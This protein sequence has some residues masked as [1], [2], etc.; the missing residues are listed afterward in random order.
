MRWWRQ[1]QLDESATAVDVRLTLDDVM[2]LGGC[3][4]WEGLQ[5]DWAMDWTLMERDRRR[6]EARVGGGRSTGDDLHT[7]PA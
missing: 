7:V 3:R 1:C 6:R 5:T 4:P 2:C